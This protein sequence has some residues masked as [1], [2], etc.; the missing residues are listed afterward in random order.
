[1]KLLHQQDYMNP[2]AAHQP[3]QHANHNE[4]AH[5]Q[6]RSLSPEHSKPSSQVQLITPANELGERRDVARQM[7]M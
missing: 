7:F 2:Y 1:M 5:L 6:Q 3:L 4:T